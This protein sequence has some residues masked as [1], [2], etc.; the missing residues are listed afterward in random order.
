MTQ[1]KAGIAQLLLIQNLTL[2]VVLEEIQL[3]QAKT[4]SHLIRLD[5]GER[6]QEV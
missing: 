3:E 5:A 1:W 6:C 2:N 4:E